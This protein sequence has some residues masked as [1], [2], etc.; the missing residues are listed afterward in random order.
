M[1]NMWRNFK[2]SWRIRSKISS[3]SL[4]F[5][6]T[7]FR[8][9]V[10]RHQLWQIQWILGIEL[11]RR[12]WKTSKELVTQSFVAPAS[13]K[14]DNWKQRRRKD[15]NTL[16]CKWWQCSVAP[17]DGHLRQPAQSQRSSSRLDQRFARWSKSSRETCC[18]GSDG[19]RNSYSTSNC[20]SPSHF[21]WSTG[22]LLQDNE[23]R[24]EKPPEE[25]EILHIVLRSKLELGQ[26]WTIL[27]C[28]SVTK[29]TANMCERVDRKSIG[30]YGIE[31]EVL[32]LF[33]DQT[34][35]W[36]RTANGVEKYVREAMP[37]REEEKASGRPAAK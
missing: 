16:H 19:T 25:P 29:W 4:V 2:K 31:V 28:S 36:I 8:K 13:L 23:R 33:V 34:I 20:K 5:P 17:N 6:W 32:S 30:R 35:S 14:G 26:D 10:V 21:F 22:N 1:K 37:I 18:R 3:Q 24:F 7:W 9:E 12:C 11:Q 27:P 15:N